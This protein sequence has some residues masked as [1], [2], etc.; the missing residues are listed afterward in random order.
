M[1]VVRS[2]EHPRP[3][4]KQDADDAL[5]PNLEYL[6]YFSAPRLPRFLAVSY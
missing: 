5:S 3:S 1:V 6:R 4:S 2:L